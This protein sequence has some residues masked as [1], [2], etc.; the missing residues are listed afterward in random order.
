MNERKSNTTQQRTCARE[1]QSLLDI[2]ARHHGQK[3]NRSTDT[4]LARFY[5]VHPKRRFAHV[6]NVPAE[7]SLSILLKK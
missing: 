2:E 4:M 3:A 5:K 1:R 7:P 6:G